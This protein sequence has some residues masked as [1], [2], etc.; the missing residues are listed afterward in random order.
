M[1]LVCF[2]ASHGCT[3][4]SYWNEVP[5]ASDLVALSAFNTLFIFKFC[6]LNYVINAV[7]SIQNNN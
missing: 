2:D 4:V 7:F 3:L 1:E 6:L 5:F